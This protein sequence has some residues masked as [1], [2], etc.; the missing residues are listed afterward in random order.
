MHN[1]QLQLIVL[2]TYLVNISY[3]YC[4]IWIL[5]C[6]GHGYYIIIHALVKFT[7]CVCYFF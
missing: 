3:N 4:S 5:R 2:S 7:F 1:L 6:F